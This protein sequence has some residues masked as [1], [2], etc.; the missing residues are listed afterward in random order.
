MAGAPVR[1]GDW[2]KCNVREED[3]QD[4]THWRDFWRA[5]AAEERMQDEGDMLV[6][7]VMNRRMLVRAGAV[8]IV[9]YILLIA[10]FVI[11]G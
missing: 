6:R 10:A 2:E 7:P 9:V 1:S 3:I 5:R 4:A 11:Y 8:A